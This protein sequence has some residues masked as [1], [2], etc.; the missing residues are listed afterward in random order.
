MVTKAQEIDLF[1]KHTNQHVFIEAEGK[2]DTISNFISD[3]NSKY[4]C[5]ISASTDGIILLKD[6]ANKW[7]LELRCYFNNSQ[8]FP[9]GVKVTKNSKYRANYQY[10]FNDISIIKQ[11]FDLNYRIGLN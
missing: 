4:S 1:F 5:N 8:N 11:L 3:Y 2:Q 9:S 7:G 6:D 10:R